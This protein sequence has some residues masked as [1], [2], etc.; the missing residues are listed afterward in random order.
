MIK[1]FNQILKV[2]NGIQKSINLTD[3]V[4]IGQKKIKQSPYLTDSN[5]VTK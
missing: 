2:I 5:L 3:G 1:S 4:L